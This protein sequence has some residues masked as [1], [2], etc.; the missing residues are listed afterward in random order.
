[1]HLTNFAVNKYSE[2]YEYNKG[3]QL[4]G[5]GSKWS[6][7]AL[8][9]KFKSLNLNWEETIERIKDVIIKTCIS[10]EPHIVNG[11]NRYEIQ[12]ISGQANPSRFSMKFMDLMLFL[13]RL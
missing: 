6:L 2:E 10:V 13:I 7:G 1:V 5:F 9:R 11:I 3:N 8:E 12:I 4:D